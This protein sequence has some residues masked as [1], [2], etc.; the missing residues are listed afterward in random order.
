MSFLDTLDAEGKQL[1][2]DYIIQCNKWI[3]YIRPK[4]IRK[5]NDYLDTNKKTFN[6]YEYLNKQYFDSQHTKKANK[7]PSKDITAKYKKLSLLF[8]PDKYSNS[9]ST[10]FFALINKIYSDNNA[11]LINAID[12]AAHLIL[13]LNNLEN[14]I[15][16]LDSNNI[17]NITRKIT[18]NITSNITN[19]LK[20][21]EN[22]SNNANTIFTILNSNG[23]V[24]LNLNLNENLN[25]NSCSSDNQFEIDKKN[26]DNAEDFLNSTIY[27]FYK[28]NKTTIDYINEQFI[29]EEQLI[30]KIRNA[31]KYERDFI[32]FCGERYQDNKNIMVALCEWIMNENEELRKEHAKIIKRKCKNA[33]KIGKTWISIF[34][35]YCN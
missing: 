14:I 23:N 5:L 30:E 20:N 22:N 28:D 24:N 17:T 32:D 12:T 21:A 33:G 2:N 18:S 6:K 27:S 7:E 3:N 35:Q 31:S 9:R 10:E 19:T 11:V 1:Y 8:H 4:A 15:T 34:Y 26:N 13:E 29:T 16:N 25:E